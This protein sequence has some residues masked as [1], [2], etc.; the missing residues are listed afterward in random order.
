M[1]VISHQNSFVICTKCIVFKQMELSPF[2][3]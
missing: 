1:V 2:N 3:C